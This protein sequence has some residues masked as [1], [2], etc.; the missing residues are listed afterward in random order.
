LEKGNSFSSHCS[1]R[2]GDPTGQP[3][4]TTATPAIDR[5]FLAGGE[6]SSGAP[7]PYGF[8]MT[9]CITT[10]SWLK[11]TG[12]AANAVMAMAVQLRSGESETANGG[13]SGSGEGIYGFLKARR[14]RQAS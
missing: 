14:T 4:L 12:T 3:E 8:T 13:Y 5:R 2:Q 11:E 6:V 10:A 1:R 9:T 7:R